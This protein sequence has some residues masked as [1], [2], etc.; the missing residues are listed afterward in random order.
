MSKAELALETFREEHGIV[1]ITKQQETLLLQVAEIEKEM[2]LAAA[3]FESSR[4]RVEELKKALVDRSPLIELSRTTGRHNFS[5]DAMKELLLELRIEEKDLSTRFQ[6]NHLPL[7][8]VRKQIIEA[9]T[10]LSKEEDTHTEVTT[11]IDLN[12]QSLELSLD[13]QR[14]QLGADEARLASLT[15]E[16]RRHKE[17]LAALASVNVR[18]HALERALTIAEEEYLQFRANLHRARTSAELDKV[19]VSNVSVVQSAAVPMTPVQ[20]RKVFIIAAGLILAVL[21]SFAVAYAVEYFDDTFKTDSD[22]D[23]LRGYVVKWLLDNCADNEPGEE[24]N[25]RHYQLGGFQSY[26]VRRVGEYSWT[27]TSGSDEA[28]AGVGLNARSVK[29]LDRAN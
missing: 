16:V 18:L 7:V 28:L 13:T 22:V 25:F 9:E 11:G 23:R 2:E 14:V 17:D 10:M 20:P 8:A 4:S 3:D 27:S 1:E 5:G 19:K 15:G 6:D 21:F 26:Q 24:A 29:T 12:V